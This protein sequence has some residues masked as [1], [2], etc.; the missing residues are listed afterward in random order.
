MSLRS[1]MKTSLHPVV[2]VLLAVSSL[3]LTVGCVPPLPEFLWGAA[4]SAY[5]VEGGNTT[6]DW[7]LFEQIPGAIEN[8]DRAGLAADHYHK[9][10]SDF[11][12][13][14][15]YGINSYRF[16][17]EWSRIEPERDVYDS[18]AID[19]YHQVLQALRER[20]IT[21]V[22]T[23]Q[24][25]TLPQWVLNPLDPD[26]ALGGW[27]NPSTVEEFVEYVA[28]LAGEFGAEVDWWLTINEPM[29]VAMSGY[30]TGNYPP[31]KVMDIPAL[32][33]VRAN[34]LFAHAR[35]YRQIKLKDKADADGD[36]LNSRVSLAKN[37][38]LFDPADS[39]SLQDQEAANSWDYFYNASLFNSL[40]QGALDVDLDGKADNTQTDPPEGVY[41]ELA[42]TL[43]F[44]AFNYYL[45]LFVRY[46]ENVGHVIPFLS[47]LAFHNEAPDI[48]RNDLGWE[49]YHEG[50]YRAIHY[51]WSHWPLR[52]LMI[53]ESGVITRNPAQKADFLINQL[54]EVQRARDENLPV[55][56][57]FWW[58]LLD[59]FE[60]TLGTKPG[61][62]LFAVRPGSLDRVPTTGVKA[63]GDI[64]AAGEVTPE[65]EEK[66]S[67]P[68][69]FL[70]GAAIASYEVEG[71]NE[72][73]D[74]Y[75]WEQIDG[76]IRNGTRAGMAADH[77]QRFREDI[78][79]LHDLGLKC[80]RL[81]LE[82]SRIEPQRDQ[83]NQEEI[84]HYHEVLDALQARGI[85]P[86]VCLVHRSLPQ[87]V[88]NPSAPEEDL[89]GWE[90]PDTVQE[91]IEY[92]ALM[93]TEFGSQV[94]L[95][96][97][98]NEPEWDSLGGYLVAGY[99]PGY[100]LKPGRCLNALSWMALAH[101][102]AYDAIKA[103]DTVDADG[104]GQ[105]ALVS[106]SKSLNVFEPYDPNDPE[107][108][109]AVPRFE[110]FFNWSVFDWITSGDVDFD[111]DGVIDTHLE[112]LE[113]RLD[114]VSITHYTRFLARAN[115]ILPILDGLFYNNYDP[116][117]EYQENGWEVYPEGIYQVC[118]EAYE[119]YSLPIFVTEH[120]IVSADDSFRARCLVKYLDNIQ[121]LRYQGIPIMGYLY[122]S[123]LDGFS[124]AE[125]LT[126]SLG[127]LSVDF[128]TFGRSANAMTNAYRDI[129]DAHGVTYRIRNQVYE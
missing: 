8:G 87:W 51:L 110:R 73:S 94:D 38:M 56:G 9:F 28:F 128:E 117:R 97:T 102:A 29:V 11:D 36:G 5:Q 33:K 72:L 32:E 44:L 42:G 21:P 86:I 127:L 68:D 6:A 113:N 92:A 40:T 119:R 19:H 3:A 81:S 76:K 41:P 49:I 64:I 98:L 65:I 99:P 88:Q 112:Q 43:D 82:W 22:V 7:Y 84:L 50:L 116:A 25:F 114:F 129:V 15:Q 30:L 59:T 106:L 66:Y 123:L 109:A 101:G 58:S 105:V 71:G 121:D 85:K 52:P 45:R 35:A 95:W 75:Q 20:N 18:P 57:F 70:W 23:L 63:Y 61:F 10:A 54:K 90:S 100:L 96:Q 26:S 93:A 104:D 1:R 14:Q 103:L 83:I 120:G 78:D 89:D 122:Y 111:M 107:D 2:L 48:E 53:T 31:G 69:D 77:Y 46:D 4:T 74:W 91:F 62:G 27:E 37:L 12:F 60:W 47:G 126:H 55:F 108:Q 67:Q 34:L 80:F 125:G 17:I 79:A 16:S 24:H 118:R 13:C 124:W 39:A 115:G